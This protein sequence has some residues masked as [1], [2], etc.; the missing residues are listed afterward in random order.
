MFFKSAT[1]F[2]FQEPF[3]LSSADLEAALAKH[4]FRA[5]RGQDAQSFGFSSP[6]GLNSTVLNHTVATCSLFQ[7]TL[8]EKMLPLEVIHAYVT[9]KECEI[10]KETGQAISRAHRRELTEL[11]KQELLPRAFSKHTLIQAYIDRKNNWLVINSTKRSQVEL[12]TACLRKALLSLPIMPL[13]PFLPIPALMTEWLRFST[14]S[15]LLF[16]G[17]ECELEEPGGDGGVVRAR[18]LALDSEEIRQH[19]DAGYQATKVK[20]NYA[21]RM[22]FTLSS[23]FDFSKIKFTDLVQESLDVIDADQAAARLDC[24]F[25][26]VTGELEMMIRHLLDVCG[27]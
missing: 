2:Q 8:E 3:D 26:I 1:F 16:L 19:L 21:E 6:F 5:A 15:N 9:E 22:I 4:P 10:K 14:K 25:A 7:I 17:D 13:S 24:E 23:N 27:C 18:R 20:L 12:I 11:A